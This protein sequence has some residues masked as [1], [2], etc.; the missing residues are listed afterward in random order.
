MEIPIELKCLRNMQNSDFSNKNNY[1]IL[2]TSLFN[3]YTRDQIFAIHILIDKLG[4][5]SNI[6]RKL[7]LPSTSFYEFFFHYNSII[8]LK[9]IN[10]II[11]GFIYFKEEPYFGSIFGFHFFGQKLIKILDF[12]I[13]NNY[14]RMYYGKEFFDYFAY[15]TGQN[16]NLMTFKNPNNALFNFLLKNYGIVIRMYQIPYKISF[17]SFCDFQVKN[18]Y[19]MN[20]YMDNY[21]NWSPPNNGYNKN[22]NSEVTDKDKFPLNFNN[23]NKNKYSRNR[24]NEMSNKR[25]DYI[26]NNYIKGFNTN[27][28]YINNYIN[29][30]NYNNNETQKSFSKNKYDFILN[31]NE[32]NK[33]DR[34]NQMM[35]NNQKNSKIVPSKYE[36]NTFNNKPINISQNNII[37]YHDIEER[38]KNDKINNVLE[39]MCIQ[40]EKQ[41]N[42]LREEKIQHPEKFIDTS[43]ALKMEKKDQGIFALALISKNLENLGIETAIVKNSNPYEENKDLNNLQFLIN[44]MI[45]K[46]KYDLHF[47]I[48]KKKKNELLQ[49]KNEYTKFKENLK[50]KISKDFGIPSDKIVITL[51]KKGGFH[52]QLIFQS[53][54]FNN[55]NKKDFIEKFKNDP[56]F[57]ELQN[58][59]DIQEDAIMGAIKLTPSQ[60]DPKGNR[61]KGWARNKKR[62]GKDYYPPL[63]WNGI[64]LKVEDRYDNG[65]NTWLGAKNVPGE[66]CVAYHGVGNRQES[67]KVKNMIG[68]IINN[69]FKAGSGQKHKN[70]PDDFHPE[71]KVG[72][73]VYCTPLITVAEKYAGKSN[74]NGITYK[75]VL[76]VRVNPDALRHCKK[77]LDSR[78]QKYW[79]VNGTNDEIRPYRILYKKCQEN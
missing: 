75:T 63:G 50:S 37:S 5:L 15:I 25:Y 35:Q 4:E 72:E 56:D 48:R 27:N 32:N 66:W 17:C 57:P 46:K 58:L 8:I 12:Y 47:E 40:G 33:K 68:E 30:D 31:K 69:E 41:K 42:E 23:Y 19:K 74:I 2:Q 6:E 79:V 11:I 60:L 54:E 9:C 78:T 3:Y 71:K 38:Q 65:D 20:N 36:E 45:H 53:D 59:K 70:C 55:L 21:K 16:H 77:C 61:K 29:N 43:Q 26:E 67:D 14:R 18:L 13:A 64:G 10:D 49:N 62:G 76:M 24:P 73:G 28:N 7:F 39:D 52:I 44:G 34:L 51:P 22:L 1:I